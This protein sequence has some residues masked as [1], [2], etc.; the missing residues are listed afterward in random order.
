MPSK[1]NKR[2]Q[3]KLLSKNST[4]T[5]QRSSKKQIS[6]AAIYAIKKLTELLKPF[7]LSATQRHRTY[8]TMLLDDAVWAGFDS[9]AMAIERAQAAG[10]FTYKK[11]S[12]ISKAIKDFFQYNMDN[13]DKQTPRSIGRNAAEMIIH[14]GVPFEKVFHKQSGFY[15]DH[16]TI[17]KLAYIHPSSLVQNKPYI[18]DDKGNS[19]THVRQSSNAFVGNDGLSYNVKD[20]RGYVDIDVRRVAFSA[21]SATD[22]NPL[23]T[24]PMDAAYVAWREKQL[25]QDYLLIGVTRDFSGTPVLRLPSEVLA[26][27]EADPTSSEAQQVAALSTGMSEMHSGDASFMI[28]PSDAQS[29]NGTGLRDYEIQFLGIDGSSKN[30]NITEIIEQKK[31]AIYNVL[32][33]QH[34]IT[35]ENGGGSY[36]LAEGT[37]NMT[38]LFSGRDN[39]IV[40]EMWNKQVFPQLLRLNGI[41]CEPEEVPKWVHGEVQPLSLSEKGQFIS[42]TQHLLPAYAS[43]GNMLLE[44]LGIDDRIPDEYTPDQVR[45]LLFNF[46][47]PSK[48]GAANGGTSGTGTKPQDN[49]DQN[50]ENK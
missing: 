5:E 12:D 14:G 28:L 40:D 6:T 44:E 31:R 33:S 45:E 4:T 20:P 30:F 22:T 8:Q 11:D 36:N 17:K 41:E 15:D 46:Q 16:F 2:Q 27:A 43:V 35:G 9:R 25:L 37:A 42:R 32:A 7:E 50:T 38:S 13:M 23:G 19:I 34:L 47:E 48:V 24:S 10:K 29:E 3:K 39:M 1:K 21:Y 18:T 26:A 49:S